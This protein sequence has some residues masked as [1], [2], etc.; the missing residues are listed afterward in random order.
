MSNPQLRLTV[1]REARNLPRLRWPRGRE[2]DE[3]PL[4]QRADPTEW[5]EKIYEWALGGNEQVVSTLSSRLAEEFSEGV[6]PALR[7]PARLR[8]MVVN[9]REQVTAEW[10]ASLEHCEAT[11]DDIA[12]SMV[13]ASAALVE[14]L[15]WVA[16][17]FSNLPGAHIVVR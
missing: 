16:E 5:H 17:T 3:S 11:E 4:P 13:N 9:M 12:P 1:Y 8:E 14:H 7:H 6:T 15:R 2:V 10:S